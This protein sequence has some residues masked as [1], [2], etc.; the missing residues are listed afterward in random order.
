LGEIDNQREGKKIVR[1]LRKTY[2]KI[3]EL[4]SGCSSYSKRER[5]KI[6][7]VWCKVLE[8]FSGCCSRSKRKGEK[9]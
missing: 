7:R 4:F 9:Q 6:V 1:A 3:L 5:E 8:L 2:C